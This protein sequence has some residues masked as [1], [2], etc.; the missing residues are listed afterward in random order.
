MAKKNLFNAETMVMNDSQSMLISKKANLSLV[1]G[2]PVIE[3]HG[4]SKTLSNKVFGIGRD[5][6]N[7]V[8]IADPKVSKFHALVSVK[9]STLFVRD[10][11]SSNGTRINGK[12]ISQ[13]VQIALRNHDLLQLGNTV[14]KVSC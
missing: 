3:A 11:G 5:K 1:Q 14:I 2:V 7:A 8:I 13:N 9:K 4:K 6:S 10:T 12:E